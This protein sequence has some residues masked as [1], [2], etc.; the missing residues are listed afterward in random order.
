MNRLRKNLGLIYFILP[1][2]EVVE[3]KLGL[4]IS[5]LLGKSK[6]RVKLKDNLRVDF[7]S[8]E[9]YT[10]LSLLGIL[11]FATSYHVKSNNKIEFTFDTKN[12]FSVPLYN[13]SYEDRNLIEVLFG[14]IKFGANFITNENAE[15]KQL[16]D[17]TFKIFQYNNKKVIEISS[18]IKFY[19]DS[20]HPG[21]TIIETFVR[22]IH[23]INS[24][25]SLENKVVIDVGAECGDTPLFF[26][27]MGATVYAFEPITEY[28]E[29]MIRNISLNPDLAPKII[30]INA[31]IGKD[32]M[33]T[34]YQ[35]STGEIP[36]TSFVSNLH[37]KNA[38]VIQTKGYS[39]ESAFEEFNIKHV[40]L[41][42]M[43]CKGCEFFITNNSLKKVD[44]VK[45]EF[46]KFQESHNLKDLLE[47]LEK[48]G[49]EYMTYKH[50][51][52]S[53]ESNLIKT[54][55]YGKKKKL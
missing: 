38:K 7:K 4:I 40:D 47:L 48:E 19:I 50:D 25:D 53:H 14:G 51:P 27:N 28:Y 9:F 2:V 37:G 39:L 33:L 55:I 13:L 16:R 45:I 3:N 46:S 43:D 36:R 11:T 29:A 18:G 6:Y 34:F 12:Y 41:L 15:I 20:I 32:G 54:T 22:N 8:T 17:K 30:P 21:N 24:F 49:F 10:M 44:S 5:I 31:A 1:Y 23:F 35:S 26:A 42:K 52:T